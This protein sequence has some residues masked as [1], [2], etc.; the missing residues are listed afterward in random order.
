MPR[1]CQLRETLV[2]VLAGWTSGPVRIVTVRLIGEPRAP[3][4]SLRGSMAGVAR[5]HA[6][7]RPAGG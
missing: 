3:S 4:S 7:C 6:A 1:D 2:P 5:G